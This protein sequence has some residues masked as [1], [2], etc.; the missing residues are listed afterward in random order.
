MEIR[1]PGELF[2]GITIRQIRKGN[3]SRRRNPLIADL[4][5]RI[6]M[7]EAWGRGV[8]LI[9]KNEPNAKFQEVAKVFIASFDRPSFTEEEQ[10]IHVPGVESGLESGPSRDQVGTKS[11]LS[12]H[13]VE[14]LRKCL[15]ESGIKELMKIA[16]RADRTKFR[17][18]VLNPLLREGLLEMTIPEKTN[19][20]LQKYRL[21]VKGKRF[22]GEN[23]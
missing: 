15:I 18:Q 6:Q 7:V 3:V 19:S 12:R 20:R 9:L 22:V 14:I 5:R 23:A 1:S 17:N 11:A 8:P 16:G 4:F 10:T 13:Q 21:T 2:N